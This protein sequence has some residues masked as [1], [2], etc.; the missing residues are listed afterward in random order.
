MGRQHMSFSPTAKSFATSRP[1][2][3]VA[4]NLLANFCYFMSLDSFMCPRLKVQ[5]C[6]L[7]MPAADHFVLRDW[8]SLSFS[9]LRIS[10]FPRPRM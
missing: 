10:L 7:L 4:A 1:G 9:S 5:Y 2:L 6:Y 8:W 3:S